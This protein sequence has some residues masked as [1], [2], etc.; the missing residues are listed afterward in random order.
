MIEEHKCVEKLSSK[1][2]KYWVAQLAGH[3]TEKFDMPRLLKVFE[4]QKWFPCFD[5]I[6]LDTMQL[7]KQ[8][9]CFEQYSEHVIFDKKLENFKLTTVV[10]ALGGE[11][12]DAHDAI[13]DVKMSIFCAKEINH[14]LKWL[15][16]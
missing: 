3:N 16:S 12:I 1:G 5:R 6:S 10:D 4:D 8:M 15:N 13:G 9:V 11:I 14:R 7:A 2:S